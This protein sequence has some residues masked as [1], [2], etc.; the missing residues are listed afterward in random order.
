MEL[1]PIQ[2]RSHKTKIFIDNQ[3]AL[4][5]T[6]SKKCNQSTFVE[7]IISN[8]HEIKHFKL[9]DN[10]HVYSLNDK[11][12]LKLISSTELPDVT[13][14]TSH[15]QPTLLPSSNLSSINGSYIYSNPNSISYISYYN[16]N[17]SLEAGYKLPTENYYVTRFFCNSNPKYIGKTFSELP[18][19]VNNI[20]ELIDRKLSNLKHSSSEINTA[21]TVFKHLQNG[22]VN[23]L[24]KKQSFRDSL[25]AN[26]NTQTQNYST[27]ILKQPSVRSR[28]DE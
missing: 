7:N 22:T 28:A 19:N 23:E 18:N 10:T 25:K 2:S 12:P 6:I 20:L 3:Q 17:V 15:W 16:G 26:I 21:I 24:D 1:R 27:P 4:I 14:F 5:K 13:Y 8:N 11:M 9:L